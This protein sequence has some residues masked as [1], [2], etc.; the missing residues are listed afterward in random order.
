MNAHRQPIKQASNPNY[1]PIA[2]EDMR[3]L[4]DESHRQLREAASHVYDRKNII[5]TEPVKTL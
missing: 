5:G 3:K 2:R 4:R 1:A